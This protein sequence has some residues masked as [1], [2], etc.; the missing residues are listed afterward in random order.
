MVK[1]LSFKKDCIFKGNNTHSAFFHWGS[2]PEKENVSKRSFLLTL[3][4]LLTYLACQYNSYIP[5]FTILLLF[6]FL[7]S[8]LFFHTKNQIKIISKIKTIN[9]TASLAGITKSIKE[10]LR[11]GILFYFGRLE[12]RK[13][14]Q[15]EQS[16]WEILQLGR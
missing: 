15:K 8:F 4:I 14:N 12:G 11:G 2:I 1:S 7:V 5:P 10:A 3:I 13:L 6:K 16:I 9:W